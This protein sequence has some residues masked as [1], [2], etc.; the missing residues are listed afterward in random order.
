VL[1]L[2]QR[3]GAGGGPRREG[4]L[5]GQE[6]LAFGSAEERGALSLMDVVVGDLLVLKPAGAEKLVRPELMREHWTQT[7]R[8]GQ[9]RYSASHA[10]ATQ[11]YAGQQSRPEERPTV[12]VAN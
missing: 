11:L 10:L 6:C 3:M 4:G 5:D 1:F 7:R 12:K 2:A 8:G 9:L